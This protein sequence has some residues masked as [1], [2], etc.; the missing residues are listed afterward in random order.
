M[1]RHEAAL[2]RLVSRQTQM[3]Q[4]HAT[5]VINQNI[6]MP[7]FTTDQTSGIDGG[8]VGGTVGGIVGVLVIIL[9]LLISAILVYKKVSQVT[10]VWV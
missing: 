8:V 5:A 9:I 7:D 1:S 4:F 10:Y 6:I 2:P 3:L